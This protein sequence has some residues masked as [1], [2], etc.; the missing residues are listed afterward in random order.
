MERQV[1]ILEDFIEKWKNEDAFFLRYPE[2][3]GIESVMFF[4][5][6]PVGNAT[7]IYGKKFF[8]KERATYAGIN[9]KSELVAIAVT[10]E[11]KAKD[12]LYI[13]DGFIFNLHERA[14]YQLPL[15]ERTMTFS[16]FCKQT[17]ERINKEIV[18][19]LYD[20]LPVTKEFTE[21]EIEV[22]K[23]RTRQILLHNNTQAFAMPQINFEDANDIAAMLCGF[24]DLEQ[25]AK[26][27]FKTKEV[28]YKDKKAWDSKIKDF[29]SKPEF[30]PEWER[31]LASALHYAADELKAAN[32]TVEFEYNGVLGSGKTAPKHILN[33]LISNEGF[34][35]Y[36][37]HS[38]KEGEK[39]LDTLGCCNSWGNR[40]LRCLHIKRIV[41]RNN[42][43]FERNIDNNI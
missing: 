20:S 31:D 37:F 34:S 5:S 38:R 30:I 25:K 1:N 43:L 3:S 14:S 8:A 23:Q 21:D 36:D 41:Y 12:M 6:I 22:C 4:T 29:I 33:H 9:H 10:G 13:V 15:P 11:D 19:P 2:D 18:Q 39:L 16:D 17:N 32:V 40:V 28:G 42:V 27:I 35:D 7:Y 24:I 26:E